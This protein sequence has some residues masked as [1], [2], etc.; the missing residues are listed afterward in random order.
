MEQAA[1][2]NDAH[3]SDDLANSDEVRGELSALHPPSNPSRDSL[4]HRIP[5]DTQ[6]LQL[7]MDE[8]LQGVSD[9]P[10]LSAAAMSPWTFELI[11]QVTFG[12]NPDVAKGV[13]RMFNLILEGKGG[14]PSL[15]TLSRLVALRKPNNSIRPIAVGD[16]WLR[17]LGKVVAKKLSKDMGEILAPH[18]LGVGIP[19]GA[20]IAVHAASLYARLLRERA[21][22]QLTLDDEE[23]DPWCLIALDFKNAFNTLGRRAIYEAI[24]VNCPELS[25]FFHWSYGKEASLRL[26]DGSFICFSSTGVRQGN[27][28]QMPTSS[29]QSLH[30]DACLL[31]MFKC[32]GSTFF[33]LIC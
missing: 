1:E 25:A 18:N 24:Q 5:R 33:L 10:A 6:C 31:F 16:V 14:D 3:I 20:E 2:G 30:I 28:F 22:G 12:P 17:L 23:D 27:M 32:V 19:G 26:G 8:L 4:P 7:S 15:W 21:S 11:K 9:L 29:A 13:L